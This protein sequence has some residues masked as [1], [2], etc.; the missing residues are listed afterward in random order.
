MVF[1][2]YIFYSLY[3]SDLFQNICMDHTIM[4]QWGFNIATAGSY[5]FLLYIFY[6]LYYSDSIS[7]HLHGSY[8]DLISLRWVSIV[9]LLYIL[10]S[11]LFRS[12]S[13]NLS[14][15]HPLLLLS[16]ILMHKFT[17]ISPHSSLRGIFTLHAT[18]NIILYIRMYMH[19]Y[20]FLM[21]FMQA[22]SWDLL[23]SINS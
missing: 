5:G 15:H 19:T 7:E 14:L 2:L 13:V 1:L 3:Y 4:F 9:F 11:L 8:E 20:L 21:P 23:C 6:S 16:L 22:Y 10:F 18:L 12:I 17:L